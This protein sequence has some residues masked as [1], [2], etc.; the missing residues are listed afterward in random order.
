LRDSDSTLILPTGDGISI[1]FSDSP[2][3]PLLLALELYKDLTRYN[4]PKKER[5][6]LYSRIGL[7]R[8]QFTSPIADEI[9]KAAVEKYN[10]LRREAKSAVEEYNEECT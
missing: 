8:G 9:A 1:G 10:D 6:K 5:Y 7:D 4:M 2:E 3:K